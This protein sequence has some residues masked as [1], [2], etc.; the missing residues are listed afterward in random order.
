MLER[1]TRRSMFQSVLIEPQMLKHDG[2]PAELSKFF[3]NVSSQPIKIPIAYYE[4]TSLSEFGRLEG[5][6]SMLS[7]RRCREAGPPS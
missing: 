3:V 2:A 1:T 7:A 5:Y 6:L 4:D